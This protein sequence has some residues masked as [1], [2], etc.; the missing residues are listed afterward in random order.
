M[1]ICTS[2]VKV[3]CLWRIILYPP[4]VIL[5]GTTSHRALVSPPSQPVCTGESTGRAWSVM[6]LRAY[7]VGIGIS[8][9]WFH[10]QSESL[11]EIGPMEVSLHLQRLFGLELQEAHLP[12]DIRGGFPKHEANSSESRTQNKTE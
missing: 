1:E 9:G 7:F 8:Q 2:F 4:A 3:C 5:G 12:P 10:F 11:Q 6:V